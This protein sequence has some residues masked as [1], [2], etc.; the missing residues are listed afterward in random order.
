MI[1]HLGYKVDPDAGVVYG[2]LG[3]T[4]GSLDTS[5]YLQLDRRSKGLP[6]MAIHRMVWEA[7]NG[8]IPEGMEI[9][10]INGVKTDNHIANLEL[11]TRQGN[12]LHAYRTGLKTNAGE[13]HPRHKLTERDVY[14]IR[15]LADGGVAHERIAALFAVKRRQVNEIARRKAWVH[16]PEKAV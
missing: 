6:A 8:S 16:L 4:V 9:N 2:R 1:Q 15:V 12:V 13:K 5:G 3:Y 11:V 14:A 7:V 10:H